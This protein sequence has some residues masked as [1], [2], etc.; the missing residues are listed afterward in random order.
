MILQ[1]VVG[2]SLAGG[3]GNSPHSVDSILSVSFL[4]SLV[5]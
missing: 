1:A 3:T 2:P 4:A 5:L